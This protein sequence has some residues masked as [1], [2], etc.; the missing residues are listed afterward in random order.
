MALSEEV[1]ILGETLSCGRIALITLVSIITLAFF[2]KS[3]NGSA[4]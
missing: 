1:W 2:V 3:L 4:L